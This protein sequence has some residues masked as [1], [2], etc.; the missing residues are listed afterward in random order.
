MVNLSAKRRS[1]YFRGYTTAISGLAVN[2]PDDNFASPTG[3]KD[4]QRL[5]RLGAKLDRSPVFFPG[6]QLRHRIREALLKGACKAAGG[7]LPL[8]DHFM[9]I[10][11][12]AIG[13]MAKDLS[14]VSMAGIVEREGGLRSV[15]PLISLGGFWK[16][17]GSLGVNDWIPV[18]SDQQVYY[19]HSKMRAMPHKR[20]EELVDLLSDDDVDKLKRIINEDGEIARK[21]REIEEEIKQVKKRYATASSAEKKKLGDQLNRL[22][23]IK[24]GIKSEKEGPTETLVR[25]VEGYEAIC[26]GTVMKSGIDITRANDLDLGFVLYALKQISKRPYVGAHAA[27]GKG[28]F[29]LD[30]EVKTWSDDLEDPITLGRVKVGL[31]DFEIIPENGLSTLQDALEKAQEAFVDPGKYGLDFGA[32][33]PQTAVA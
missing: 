11:G 25:P 30:W 21:V 3:T 31:L 23:E 9:L 29:A 17:A 19:L 6:T 28:E 33:N 22:E 24:S 27:D 16:H 1:I 32:F 13:E 8:Q 2:R 4:L 12:V 15:N 5:P 20:N 7:Q 10:Q 18:D 26:P 14:S